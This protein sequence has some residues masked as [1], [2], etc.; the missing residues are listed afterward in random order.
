M[1]KKKL[2]LITMCLGVFSVTILFFSNGFTEEYQYFIDHEG[3]AYYTVQKGDTLWDLSDKFSDSPWLWPDLWQ[4]N[5]QIPNPHLIYPGERIR[6]LHD[7]GV[8]IESFEHAAAEAVESEPLLLEP[9]P[10]AP[11]FKYPTIDQVGFILKTPVTP[12]GV[13][14]K[15]KGDHTRISQDDIVYI[16]PTGDTT[17]SPGGR[18][19]VYRTFDPIIDKATKEHIGIQHYLTGIVEIM[20]VEPQFAIARVVRSFRPIAIND[21]IIPHQ[22]RSPQIIFTD[23]VKGL[24]GKILLAEEHQVLIGQDHVVFI[25]KGDKDGIKPGQQYDVYYQESQSGDTAGQKG[26]VLKPVVFGNLL[27][28]L[29]QETTATGL[30]TYSQKDIAPGDKI[31]SPMH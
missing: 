1:V 11:S 22:S 25:D 21:G 14:F 12:Q 10:V 28:L 4:E 24:K 8:E 5:P 17:L 23:T 7:K 27:V 2:F 30:I 13:I 19:T 31:A 16:K 18:H 29:A 9:K 3:G 26:M 6:L 20:E 15:V